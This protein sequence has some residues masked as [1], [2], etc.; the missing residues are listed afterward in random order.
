MYTWR[1][2][3]S[4]ILCHLKPGAEANIFRYTTHI[5]LFVHKKR[6]VATSLLTCEMGFS[7]YVGLNPANIRTFSL[8]DDVNH[9]CVEDKPFG[10]SLCDTVCPYGCSETSIE[11]HVRQS[12]TPALLVLTQARL[13]TNIDFSQLGAFLTADDRWCQSHELA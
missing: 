10:R 8:E 12:Q 4:E 3:Q 7:R 11:T 1:H 13:P 6:C 9:K 2:F 5:R